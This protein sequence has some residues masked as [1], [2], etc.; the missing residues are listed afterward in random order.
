MT[1]ENTAKSNQ[2]KEFNES[3][4]FFCQTLDKPTEFKHFRHTFESQAGFQFCAG[5]FYH[6]VSADTAFHAFSCLCEIRQWPPSQLQKIVWAESFVSNT[7]ASQQ[8]PPH[9]IQFF[10]D[11]NLANLRTNNKGQSAYFSRVWFSMSNAI[12][13]LCTK[14]YVKTRGRSEKS[15]SL[16]TA[17]QCWNVNGNSSHSSASNYL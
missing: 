6:C 7:L 9:G 2:N 4:V 15:L 1:A 10:S 17:I 13:F 8:F 16:L 14:V 11:T 3:N 12:P 5:D